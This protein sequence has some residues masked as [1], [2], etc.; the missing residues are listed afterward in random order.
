MSRN[1]QHQ[2]IQNT[3]NPLNKNEER[4]GRILEDMT[5]IL[6]LPRY[7]WGNPATQAWYDHLLAN[8]SALQE[9]VTICI[10]LEQTYGDKLPLW[11]QHILDNLEDYAQQ[12]YTITLRLLL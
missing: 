6:L 9:Q 2:D 8:T 11:L 5:I 7:L 10:L 3:L 4:L 1:D 12:R